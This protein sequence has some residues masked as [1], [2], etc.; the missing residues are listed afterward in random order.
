MVKNDVGPLVTRSE[1]LESL[2]EHW[3]WKSEPETV[4]LLSALGRVCS[5]DIASK[6]TLPVFRSAGRDGIAVRYADFANGLPDT[7]NWKKKSD[8]G[9]ADTGDDFDDAFDTVIAIESLDFRE[10][11]QTFTIRAGEKI[12]AGQCVNLSGSRLEKGEILVHRGTVI[13]CLHQN[14][15]ASGGYTEINVQKRPN[16]AYIPTGNELI[17]AGTPLERGQNIESNGVMVESIINSWGGNVTRYPICLDILA[18]LEKM[19]SGALANA[20]IVLVNGG[21]S[22]GSEDYNTRIIQEKSSFFQHGVKS[23]PGFPVGLAIIEGKPVINLPGPPVATLCGLDWCIRPL[24]YHAQGA[25]EQRHAIKVTLKSKATSPMPY[26]FYQGF[27]VAEENGGFM[28]TPLPSWHGRI[29]ATLGL[30]NAFA[31]IPIGTESIEAG[32]IID[33]TLVC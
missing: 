16:I 25:P 17:S 18:D 2:K 13:N 3:Q 24:Y 6:N 28:A 31:V 21:S 8:Y 23:I 33:V 26:D 14:M 22:K 29:T 32:A 30:C 27:H 12:T 20:D 4:P 15:L 10:D 9:M 7:S 5:E 19:L 1:A 11:M